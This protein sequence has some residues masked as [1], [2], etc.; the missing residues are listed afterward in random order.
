[1]AEEQI[2]VRQ[3]SRPQITK[4]LK[5]RRNED[6]PFGAVNITGYTF[7]LIVKRA[8]TDADSSALFDLS[9][10]IV[11]AASGIYR[12]T[13]TSEHTAFPPGVYFGEI[14]WWDG[15][16]SN[17]PPLDAIAVRYIVQ[18]AVQKDL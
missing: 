6:D 7:K 5:D 15:S 17:N 13:L 18:Q 3:N 12:F 2:V 8:F 1:M 14:R 10:T 4:V 11:T 16:V 9:G